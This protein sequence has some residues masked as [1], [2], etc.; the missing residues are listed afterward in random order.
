M[1]YGLEGKGPCLYFR[2]SGLLGSV[3][4]I[5]GGG[6]GYCSLPVVSTLGSSLSV[7]FVNWFLVRFGLRTDSSVSQNLWN[8]S[9]SPFLGAEVAV[10]TPIKPPIWGDSAEA[11]QRAVRV[12]WRRR[13][14]SAWRHSVSAAAATA[15]RVGHLVLPLQPWDRTYRLQKLWGRDS[16]FQSGKTNQWERDACRENTFWFFFSVYICVCE[17]E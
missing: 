13:G 9:D 2:S 8:A 14:T 17:R 12:L 4:G 7:Y 3:S 16:T 11:E 6:E 15:D 1:Y 10:R 5:W